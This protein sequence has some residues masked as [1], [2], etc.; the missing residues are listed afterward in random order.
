MSTRTPPWQALQ[1]YWQGLAPRERQMVLAGAAALAV[2]LLWWLAIQPVWRTWQDV[3]S[4]A[5]ALEVQWLQ[6]QQLASDARG[7]KGQPPVDAAQ[8]ATA[9]KAATDSLGSKAKLTLL[10]DR[11]TVTFTGVTPE[12]LRSWLQ[13]VRSAARGRPLNLNLRRADGGLSGTVVIALPG[14]V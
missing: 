3:P 8:A 4:Q 6:M 12:Q 14:A 11:A 7:L 9:M 5:R 1:P 2:L 13:A 10:G